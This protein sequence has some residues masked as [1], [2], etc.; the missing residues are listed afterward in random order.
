MHAG[1]MNIAGVRFRL[2]KEADEKSRKLPVCLGHEGSV[3]EMNEQDLRN[4]GAQIS[5]SPPVHHHVEDPGVIA[6]DHLSYFK[7]DHWTN[8]LQPF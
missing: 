8:S 3:A 5:P 6:D 2:R 7:W 4:R 1:K